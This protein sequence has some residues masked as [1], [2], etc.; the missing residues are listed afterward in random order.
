[1]G[2]GQRAKRRFSIVV[3]ASS[4]T[5][6]ADVVIPQGAAEYS[7]RAVDSVGVPVA[8]TLADKVTPGKT[9][10]FTAGET[11]TEDDLCLEEAITLVVVSAA[12]GFVEVGLWES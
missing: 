8:W 10:H 6:G 2:C 7:I 4:A 12:G 3:L 5:A 9:I 1:M 11:W